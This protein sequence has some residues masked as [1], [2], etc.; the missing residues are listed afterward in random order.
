[1]AGAFPLSGFTDK[2]IP[3]AMA[4]M[5][6]TAT[7]AR[8]GFLNFS[9]ST[10]LRFTLASP[11]AIGTGSPFW[12][13]ARQEGFHSEMGIGMNAQPCT[14][15]LEL[16]LKKEPYRKPAQSTTMKPLQDTCFP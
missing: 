7:T 14:K 6:A 1:V 8:S 15:F 2:P 12:Q 13:L 10:T 11:N 16:L 4:A 5:T 9:T 3:N